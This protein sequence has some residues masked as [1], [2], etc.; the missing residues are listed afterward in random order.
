MKQGQNIYRHPNGDKL[1]RSCCDSLLNSS[2]LRSM[3]R[4]ILP[5]LPYMK[6]RSDVRDVVYLNWMV[7]VEAFKDFIPQGI[8]IKSREGR[9]IFSILTYRHQHFGPLLSGSLRRIFPSPL[10]SNWR[11]YVDKL[12]DGT[13]AQG[14]VLFLKNVMDSFLYTAGSR[15]SSDALPSH[16][17]AVFE[18]TVTDNEYLTRIESGLGS[19]TAL[20]CK[21]QRQDDKTLLPEFAEWFGDWES[22]LTELCMQH[23]AIAVA[24]DINRIGHAGIE[25][26]IDIAQVQPLSMQDLQLPFLDALKVNPGQP[27][28]FVVPCIRFDVLWEHLL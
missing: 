3:R 5:K 24:E 2:T 11:L 14:I 9:A 19:A 26:P 21:A 22:A 1:W 16:L 23:S 7:D 25:L 17:A 10:Q 6:L 28:A 4:A 18:H 27:F 8:N 12:P 15:I 20:F 13:P